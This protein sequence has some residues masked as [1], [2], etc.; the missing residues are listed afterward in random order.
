MRIVAYRQHRLLGL[1]AL[2]QEF[3]QIHRSAT[4]SITIFAYAALWNS[5]NEAI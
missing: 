5:E 2:G 3:G 1:L 4:G